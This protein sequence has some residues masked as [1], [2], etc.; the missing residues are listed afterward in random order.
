MTMAV[1][2]RQEAPKG[3]PRVTVSFQLKTISTLSILSVPNCCHGNA[4]ALPKRPSKI[5][6]LIKYLKNLIRL[7]RIK[8]HKPH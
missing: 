8:F 4:A 7:P 6:F 3:F 2:V 5:Q 1:M